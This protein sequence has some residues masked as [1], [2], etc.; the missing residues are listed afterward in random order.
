MN[1]HFL[2]SFQTTI[3]KLNHSTTG[4]FWTIWISTSLLALYP[5]GIPR[6]D[7]PSCEAP[8]EPT[9]YV[10]ENSRILFGYSI[11]IDTSSYL[12]VRLKIAWKF[13]AEINLNFHRYQKW[14][15]SIRLPVLIWN[16]CRCSIKHYL[17]VKPQTCHYKTWM[18][19]PTQKRCRRVGLMLLK[20]S[21][22]QVGGKSTN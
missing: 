15:I 21:L 19:S 10:Y 4:H 22:S 18:V 2:C 1:I 5:S 3:Q 20:N 8:R 11:T 6:R 9:I 12:S 17:C 16:M 13:Q 7:P 14:S